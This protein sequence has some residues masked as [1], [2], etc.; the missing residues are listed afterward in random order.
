RGFER[1][2]ILLGGLPGWAYRIR[3]AESVR[4]LPDWSYVTISFAVAASRAPESL[5]VQAASH[6]SGSSGRRSFSEKGGT[7]SWPLN[8]IREAR[9]SKE[10]SASFCA[11]LLS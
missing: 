10:Q 7:A 2:H 6:G 8:W 1:I 5:R 9:I 3:T 4:E 11:R